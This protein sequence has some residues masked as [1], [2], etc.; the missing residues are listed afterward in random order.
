MS[1]RGASYFFSCAQL[2]PAVLRVA[3]RKASQRW[4]RENGATKGHTHGE[5]AGACQTRARRL[6]DG[7][8]GKREGYD[9][10]RFGRERMH[11][12][13][14]AKRSRHTRLHKV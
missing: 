1:R 5:Y 11:A 4:S 10:A 12:V 13:D 6:A 2:Q 7:L 14:E 9:V 8:R 3:L